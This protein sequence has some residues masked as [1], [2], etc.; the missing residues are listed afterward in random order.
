MDTEKQEPRI[1]NQEDGGGVD[2]LLDWFYRSVQEEIRKRD[3]TP[4]GGR[5]AFLVEMTITG[6][7]DARK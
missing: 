2:I 7:T 1:G 6:P 4:T 5:C 3:R